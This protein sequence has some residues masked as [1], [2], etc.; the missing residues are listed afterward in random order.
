LIGWIHP[1]A[2]G[3]GRTARALFYWVLLNNGYWLAEYLT[4]SRIILKN[5][6]QY[7]KAFLYAEADDN[8]IT[9]FIHYKMKAM[10]LAFQDL[11][12]YIQR[13]VKERKKLSDFHKLDELNQR[14]AEILQWVSEDVDTITTVKEVENRLGVT[15]Q[16]ARTDLGGLVK[17]EWLAQINLN[18]KKKGYVGGKRL[19]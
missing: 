15:N 11:Q 10:K 3:N 6:N 17:L 7:Y 1:F 12:D 5:K 18:G 16:T 19:G 14:Q 9:Y 13:K 2:D 4:I 8:D